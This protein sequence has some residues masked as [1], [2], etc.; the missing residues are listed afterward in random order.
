MAAGAILGA[1]TVDQKQIAFS[2]ILDPKSHL[3]TSIRE[4]Q[5]CPDP[6]QAVARTFNPG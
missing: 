2:L 3:L 6:T 5:I 4:P 1:V